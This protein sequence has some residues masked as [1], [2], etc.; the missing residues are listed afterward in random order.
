M[1]NDYCAILLS[2]LK[3]DLHNEEGY[4]DEIALKLMRVLL[5]RKDLCWHGE[6][7]T[8]IQL[9]QS[10]VTKFGHKEVYLDGIFCCQNDKYNCM[11]SASYVQDNGCILSI[12]LEDID[13]EDIYKVLK[14]IVN[15][16]VMVN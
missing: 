11:F 3:A 9:E 15:C 16:K 12:P 6:R 10:V 4:F 1:E 13:R 5:G 2:E 14:K 8:L 7:N